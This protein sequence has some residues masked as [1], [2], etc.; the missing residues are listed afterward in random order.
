MEKKF[1]VFFLF[2]TKLSLPEQQLTKN[3]FVASA[4]RLNNKQGGGGRLNDES[5]HPSG[6]CFNVGI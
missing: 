4:R 3:I 5:N 6:F 2:K 1:K